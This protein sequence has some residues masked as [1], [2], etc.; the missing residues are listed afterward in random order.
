M[1]RHHC[2]WLRPD[3][4]HFLL[5]R[6][7][8]ARP[9]RAKS[10]ADSKGDETQQ[11]RGLETGPNAFRHGDAALEDDLRARTDKAVRAVPGT[12]H[13][14]IG[15]ISGFRVRNAKVLFN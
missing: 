3:S 4:W 9:S 11:G 7:L 8:C 6:D 1:G 5:T 13:T 15:I 14:A 12:D 2:R 10:E